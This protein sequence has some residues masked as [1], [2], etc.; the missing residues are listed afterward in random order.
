MNA[1]GHAIYYECKVIEGQPGNEDGAYV[2][3][4]AK[5][6]LARNRLG[7]YA[8]ADTIDTALTH[9]RSY[10]PLVVGTDWTNDMFDPD[11][12]GFVKPTGGVAGGHCYLWYG[13]RGDVF[14]F[15]NSW[16]DWGD[17]GSFHMHRADFE[18]LFSSWG[19][20]VASVELAL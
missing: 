8:F 10:G 15:K 3:D 13:V 18:V 19:E 12:Q 4:G 16:G 1:D 6:M 7:V 2:R 14:D 11:A 17:N 20:V 9:L 5:A